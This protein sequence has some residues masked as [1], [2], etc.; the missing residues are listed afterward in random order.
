[1]DKKIAKRLTAF[2]C[3]L[4]I[5][6]GCLPAVYADESEFLSDYSS[7]PGWQI[8]KAYVDGGGYIDSTE[9]ASGN[10]S[11]KLYNN[12]PQAHNVYLR[13]TYPVSVKKG[14]SY[15][16]GF[17]VKAKNA[18]N[19]ATMMDWGTRSSLLPS[20]GTAGWREFEF[21][22]THTTDASV[23]L[24]SIILDTKYLVRRV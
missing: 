23:A 10:N 9:H 18:F 12:T 16:Y 7:V 21:N 19:V 17:K 13:A 24:L 14:A 20:G 5:F 3:M 22:Y 6:F 8:D 2:I 11:M 1:M 4:A 15:H